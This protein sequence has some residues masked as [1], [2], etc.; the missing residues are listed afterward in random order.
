MHFYL[1]VLHS[2]DYGERKVN[3]Y[4][5]TYSIVILRC[6]FVAVKVFV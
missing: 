4:I 3:I 1:V 6:D 2:I 5:F